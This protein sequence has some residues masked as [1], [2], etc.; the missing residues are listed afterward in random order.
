MS[1]LRPAPA[2]R[3]RPT[4]LA[5][6]AAAVL[7][8][9]ATDDDSGSSPAPA[10]TY[11]ALELNI[12]HINDHHSQL[13]AFPGTE[14]TLDG[15]ATQ[16]ELGGFAR[17]TTLFKA[18]QQ[19]G[20][21]NLL[22][23]HAGDALTGSLY[24]TFFKGEAD[25]KMMNTV[26]FDAVGYGNH[27]FDDGDGVL[28]TFV[29]QLLGGGCDT[30]V[31]SANVVPAAG[32]PLAPAGTPVHKPYLIKTYDGVKVGIIGI[33]IAGKTTNSSRPLATTQFLD[34]TATAQKSIDE[35]KAQ[36][37]RHIVLLTHQGYEADRR[38][39]AAL[40]DVD[41]IIGADSHTLLGDFSRFG[42]SS[43]GPYP[44]VEKNR[45]GE[46]VCIGQAWE[47][48]KAFGLMNVRFDTRGA[49]A[50][51]G[52]QASLVIGD[53]FK[54]K[55]EAGTFVTVD[56]ATRTALNAR[57]AAD[58]GIKVAAPDPVAAGVLAGYTAQVDAQKARAIG[59]ASQALCL[60]RVPGETTNRSGGV[61]GCESANTLAR[62]SDAAQ[63]VAE[64]FLR[65]SKRADVALQNAGG[66]RTAI[67]AGTITMNTAFTVLPFT[68]V[69]VELEVTG[70]QIVAAL[71][72]GVANHLDSAQ[73]NGSHPY[74]AGLRWAL[75]LSQPKGR[76]FSQ[77]EVKNRS[78]GLWSAID[79]ARSY[80]LVT[81]DF[82]ASGKDGY[83]TFAPI[84]AAGKFVNTYL[85][86]TQ[87]FADHVTALGTVARPAA[88]DYAHQKVTT[89]AGVVL[90]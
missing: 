20:T 43:S 15:V 41:V 30:T 76:R 58:A 1:C 13:E 25:A 74:A 19:A 73:S 37:V 23:L 31:V 65:A 63:V 32:S 5:L 72:D 62:G 57:L 47:Y 52:G 27:E 71:E 35:L 68:N 85:L 4:L 3:F 49:V 77:V 60:V 22:K 50:S 33:D 54:R 26:C 18:Q 6:M 42:L 51:C 55:N 36:G 83:A 64:A 14:L 80:V 40:S 61:A 84:Y 7:G 8:A 86:Y 70:A 17:L 82:V 9:C 66:V 56:E 11:A 75:D 81:N 59:T 67:A 87:T 21:K 79:P 24:Y 38:M 29:D 46:T 48:S 10:P 39:A 44:T 78:T 88:A 69:L 12:A 34:E 28:R 53:S 2:R 90:P 45:S 16:V 89:K